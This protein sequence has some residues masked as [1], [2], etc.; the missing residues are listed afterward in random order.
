MFFIAATAAIGRKTKDLADPCAQTDSIGEGTKILAGSFPLIGQ[1]TTLPRAQ[2][3]HGGAAGS[4]WR[5][6]NLD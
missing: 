4:S 6:I 2:Q 3:L 1:D 5:Q